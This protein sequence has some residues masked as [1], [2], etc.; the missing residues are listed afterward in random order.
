MATPT[1]AEL[2]KTAEDLGLEVDEKATVPQL[3]ELI[4]SVSP[5]VK[6]GATEE[7]LREAGVSQEDIDEAVEDGVEE[8][9][10]DVAAADIETPTIPEVKPVEYDEKNHQ[11]EPAK[12]AA[13]DISAAAEIGAAIAKGLA[14]AKEDKKMVIT[15]DE[16]VTPRF[17]LVKDKATGEILTR[18]NESGVLTK[19]QLKSIEEKQRDLQGLDVEEV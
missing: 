15:A 14:D 19:L 1:K 7:E 16:S 9:P 10:A 6:S 12:A 17:S 18:E 13:S 2:L 4:E 3:I 5:E 11:S 8:T